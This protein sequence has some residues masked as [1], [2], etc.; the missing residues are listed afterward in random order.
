MNSNGKF[1]QIG[2]GLCESTSN[3][4]MMRT[5][6]NTQRSHS[7]KLPALNSLKFKGT[8]TK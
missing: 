5:L 1:S 4:T 8:L 2:R 6:P 3:K 7:H